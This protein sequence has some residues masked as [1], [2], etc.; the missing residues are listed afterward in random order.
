MSATWRWGAPKTSTPSR[1]FLNEACEVAGVPHRTE[2]VSRDQLDDP[3]IVTKYGTTMISLAKAAYPQPYV[4]SSV[5]E[6]R[7]DYVPTPLRDGLALTIEWM[8]AHA[9]I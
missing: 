7:L 4:D 2:E 1:V 5:T 8:R 3:D 6:Q 9:F